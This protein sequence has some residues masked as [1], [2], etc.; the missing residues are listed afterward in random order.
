M[1]RTKPTSM[2]GHIQ[3]SY[4]QNFG[5]LYARLVH[6]AEEAH[7][8]DA[9]ASLDSVM[10]S[11]LP[12][13]EQT[14]HLEAQERVRV[15]RRL[16]SVIGLQASTLRQLI[17]H[18]EQLHAQRETCGSALLALYEGELN[19]VAPKAQRKVPVPEG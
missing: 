1:V 4:V 17:I 6:T 9:V 13:F 11:K 8:W 16:L 18:A 15:Y 2:P 3:A 7:D 5:K 12:L 14:D 10:C 19:P